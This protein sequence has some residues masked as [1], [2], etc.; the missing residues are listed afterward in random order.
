MI[1]SINLKP[2]L[3]RRVKQQ[4]HESLDLFETEEP[5]EREEIS[6]EEELVNMANR[7]WSWRRS[8]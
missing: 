8:T 4:F 2:S 5:I 3:L 1:M 7:T 6:Q